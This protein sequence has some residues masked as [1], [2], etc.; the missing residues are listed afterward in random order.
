MANGENVFCRKDGRY[1]ARYPK[2]RKADGTLLYGF[3]YGRTYAEAKEKADRARTETQEKFQDRKKDTVRLLCDG[4]LLAQS[5]RLKPASYA[6]YST[7]IRKH[8]IP[9]FGDK[10]PYEIRSEDIDRFTQML[11][12]E[13]KLAVKTVRDI[14]ALLHSI[15]SHGRVRSGQKAQSPEITYPKEYRKIV[16]VLDEKEEAALAL[17]LSR[18]MDLSKFGIYMALR[19]GMRIGEICALRW[20][21]I[22][23]E[24]STITVCHTAQRI[25]LISGNTGTEERRE[26]AGG[27]AEGQNGKTVDRTRTAV[28]L[29]TPKSDSSF[30]LIPLMPDM[31]ALCSRFR[32]AVPEAFVLTGTDRCMDPRTL[33]RHFKKYMEECGIQ[34]AHFHSLRHTFATRCVEAGFDIKTLSEI[35]GHSNVNITLNKYVHPN[36]ELKRRNMMRLKTLIS[37]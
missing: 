4:W 6:K 13:K 17:L 8:I 30:R 3:C 29:G 19:T 5:S 36:L 14:L 25:P 18:D 12:H 32:S 2:G 26:K 16:R 33:Q 11:L 23:F 7:S 27:T 22:S 37:P 31:A 21:D 24:T 34:A 10:P 15:L 1:E 20:C 28:I 9:F 35:L